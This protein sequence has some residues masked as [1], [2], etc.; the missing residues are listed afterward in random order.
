MTDDRLFT[1]P[2]NRHS[3]P[4]P[5]PVSLF[6]TTLRDGEQAPGVALG[7]DDKIAIAKALDDLGVARIEAGFAAGA[8]QE[9]V[10]LKEIA[11]LGLNAKIYSLARCTE[12]DI[13]AVADTGLSNAH[14]FLASSD[15]HLRHKLSLGRDEAVAKA[16]S[17]VEYAKSLGLNVQFSCEDATRTDPDFL[18]R[19]YAAVVE[20][21]ADEIDIPDTV[22][23]A[24]PAAMEYLAGRMSKL[25]V[26]V[27]V[28]C[29]NDLGLAVANSLAAMSAGASQAHVSVIGLGERTGNAALEEMALTLY[30]NHGHRVVDLSKLAGVARLVS[31]YSG[32][33]IHVNKP[34]VG[35]DAFAHESGI[36][37]HGMLNDPTTYEA[38]APELV[39]MDRSIKLGKHSGTHSLSS[40]LAAMGMTFPEEMMPELLAEVKTIALGGKEINDL[41]LAAV[42]GGL[43]WKGRPANTVELKRFRVT[44]GRG[45]VP[46]AYVTVSIGGEERSHVASGNGPVDASV[47]ALR[48]ALGEPISLEEFRVE[49]ITGGT[50]ALGE[51]TVILK[52]KAGGGEA[53]PGKAV[54]LDIVDTTMVAIL[55]AINRIYERR[56]A[57]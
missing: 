11:G 50:D 2:F 48:G 23:A 13:D 36:H 10:S 38:Y 35:R 21:G 31:R 28:H 4:I 39:G 16:V 43:M 9:A 7:T 51:V 20:A 55:E 56:K 47:N 41:E 29:H 25:G 49:A 5:G 15:S 22:G 18:E 34:V 54:G 44:T 26:P 6:D 14:L 12:K 46:E 8:A 1:S 24:L 53:T 17:A 3:R 45:I 42:A 57:V 32:R 40:R 52:D 37:V 33:A 19:F 27:A 30:L